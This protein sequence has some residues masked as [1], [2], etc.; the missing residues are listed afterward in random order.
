[1]MSL[2]NGHKVHKSSP[3]MVRARSPEGKIP[4][5]GPMLG[6][7]KYW[8]S[9]SLDK[10]LTG[11]SPNAN[12]PTRRKQTRRISLPQAL[13]ASSSFA[14][15]VL[16]DEKSFLGIRQTSQSVRAITRCNSE[17]VKSESFMGTPDGH[18]KNQEYL[19]TSPSS[20]QCHLAI[21][22]F[23]SLHTSDDS[24]QNK[25]TSPTTLASL[26][27]KDDAKG[28]S[29]LSTI[30]DVVDSS[31]KGSLISCDQSTFEDNINRQQ[32]GERLISISINYRQFELIDPSLQASYWRGL[33]NK[34]RLEYAGLT[35]R[36]KAMSEDLERTKLD[37]RIART[38]VDYLAKENKRLKAKILTDSNTLSES[39]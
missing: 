11:L 8:F 23:E 20:N 5:D 15:N 21:S 1:A 24:N 38:E 37:L 28:L 14:R 36:V 3:L 10:R 25:E 4:E 13:Y 33:A 35:L 22:S 19:Q 17:R 26:L 6:T 16:V 31:M 7:P 39:G 2:I 27:Q 30:T 12:S 34:A 32:V 29:K 9:T 18:Q